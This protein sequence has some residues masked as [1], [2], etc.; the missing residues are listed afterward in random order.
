MQEKHLAL[1]LCFLGEF[2]QNSPREIVFFVLKYRN[3]Q[4]HATPIG[5]ALL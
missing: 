4:P 5:Q 1:F 3:L 2:S